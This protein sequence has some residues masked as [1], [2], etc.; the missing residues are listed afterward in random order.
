LALETKGSRLVNLGCFA[1][2]GGFFL[3]AFLLV[4]EGLVFD[5]LFALGAAFGFGVALFSF[6]DKEQWV[7]EESSKILTYK[8]RIRPWKNLTI[9]ANQVEKAE[10]ECERKE[11]RTSHT[12][13]SDMFHK[14]EISHMNIFTLF[15][16][17]KDGRR[18]KVSRE[19]D[20]G[21]QRK[22][23]TR[24]TGQTARTIDMDEVK[25]E[26]KRRGRV[27][28]SEEKSEEPVHKGQTL[29]HWM[30]LLNSQDPAKKVEAI[31]AIGMI[32]KKAWKAEQALIE[33]LK[34]ED[35][36]VR[37]LAA[38]HIG[39]V[40][41]GENAAQALLDVLKGS[42]EVTRVRASAAYSLGQIRTDMADAIPA[43]SEALRSDDALLSVNA[44]AS[45]FKVDPGT[46]DKVLTVLLNGLKDSRTFVR[47]TAILALG[48]MGKEA[49]E[50]VRELANALKDEDKM[51]R[52]AAAQALEAMGDQAKDAVPALF[53]ALNDEDERFR[54]A[55][56]RALDKI[57]KS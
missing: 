15:L 13:R 40:D 25:K 6:F 53:E 55:A 8:S 22:L 12:S 57:Q 43:L 31:M 4:K 24:V 36:D 46:S 23:S 48:R 32:G 49:K 39:S 51:C 29:S 19:H 14:E 34:N 35:E 38:Q 50:A 45:L 18:I 28:R 52:L 3:L 10:L 42:Q 9:K 54:K 30:E 44:A 21:Y 17:M 27:E 33:A 7:F 41:P 20:S 56:R 11:F 5:I 1:I 2:I 37:W 26:S 16:I 47:H